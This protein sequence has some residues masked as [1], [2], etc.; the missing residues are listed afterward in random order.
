MARVVVF[1]GLI[2]SGKSTLAEAYANREGASYFNT[3]RVRKELLGIEVT[4]HKPAG[5][6]EG[7]Y[8]PE[9]TRRTY[10]FILDM[11]AKLLKQGRSVVL[12]GSYASRR[13]RELI[14]EC[15]ERAGGSVW[16]VF[17]QCSDEETRK[18]LEQRRRDPEAVSDGR[19]EIFTRQKEAFEL[20][21]EIDGERLL[22]LN[23][24]VDVNVLVEKV[25]VSGW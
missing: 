19:W 18:R 2:A 1:F 13:E 12:D 3:D 24:E 9:M 10:Q 5:M 25:V 7:I 6:G 17:C 21:D 8:T 14:I 16:F 15:G 4:E 20:P 22:V 11:T 23:T